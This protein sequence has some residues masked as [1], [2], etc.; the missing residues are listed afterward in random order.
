MAGGELK[1]CLNGINIVAT[2]RNPDTNSVLLPSLENAGE[3]AVALRINSPD[4]SKVIYTQP[5]SLR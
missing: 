3:C 4:Q 5:L 1:S 2:Q